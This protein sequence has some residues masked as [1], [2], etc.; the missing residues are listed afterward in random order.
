MSKY[1]FSLYLLLFS[2]AIWSQETTKKKETNQKAEITQDTIKKTERY[3]LRIGADIS[4]LAR[5]IYDK[6]YKGIELV[7]DYRVTKRMYAAAEVGNENKTTDDDRLNFTTKGSYLKI[8]P[9]WNFYQNWLD[10]ENMIH[11]GFRYGFSTFN[12]QLNS[13]KIY[14]TSGYFPQ[15][16]AVAAGT[17][18]NGL[19]AHCAEI[20]AGMKAKLFNN[21]YAGFSVRLNYLAS[22]KEPDNFANLYIPGFNR[23]YDGK[24]GA[25]YNYTIT[26]F[27]PLYKKKQ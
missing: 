17:K 3:G 16:P 19:S 8:G 13:Y 14:D 5:S 4:K 1:S 9:E 23:T 24:F 27:I 21:V 20:V 12:Q 11:L 2:I 26:Y 10:M 6:D 22:Q 7:G 15:T 25:G 18:F